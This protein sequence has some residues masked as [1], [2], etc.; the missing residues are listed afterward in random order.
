V[1][2]YSDMYDDA[3][4]MMKSEELKAFDLDAEPAKLRDKYGRDRFGQGCLLGSPLGRARRAL[5]RG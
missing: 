1:R 3:I 4:K 5:R 2:A